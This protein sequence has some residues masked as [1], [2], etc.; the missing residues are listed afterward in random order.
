MEGQP[1]QSLDTVTLVTD[2]D[3]AFSWSVAKVN[4]QKV[5]AG[6]SGARVL[7]VTTHTGD[8]L[9]WNPPV[10]ESETGKASWT[11]TSTPSVT[12]TESSGNVH[13]AT[14]DGGRRLWSYRWAASNA[15]YSSYPKQPQIRSRRQ[16]R[17]CFS[18]RC[19]T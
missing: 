12:V 11:D 4:M 15:R 2:E 1:L 16:P 9:T 14:K 19:V 13:V 10:M 6:P 5:R 18:R 7:V 3:D 17:D 8:I